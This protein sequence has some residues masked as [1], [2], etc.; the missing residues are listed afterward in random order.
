MKI[1]AAI[2]AFAATANAVVIG[3][4]EQGAPFT[5]CIDVED[6]SSKTLHDD[7]TLVDRDANGCCP[8]NTVPGARAVST[9][10]G[11]QIQCGFTDDYVT[12]GGI[13]SASS[14]SNGVRSCSYNNCYVVKQDLTC[15]DDT[16]QSL[17]GCCG[18]GPLTFSDSCSHYHYTNPMNHGGDPWM[19]CLTY[20]KVYVMEHTADYADD[21]VD[22]KFVPGA[23]YTY[24]PCEGSMAAEGYSA[25]TE[26]SEDKVSASSASGV[27]LGI[28]S[29]LALFAAKALM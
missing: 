29:L 13:A 6:F 19:Y 11:A 2:A 10:Q 8:D 1:F 20:N 12:T 3:E 26:S 16:K 15:S 14:T 28:A 25:T 22:D 17:N 7:I 9:Y 5:Q 24:T 27:N 18:D 21:I 23:F 4:M